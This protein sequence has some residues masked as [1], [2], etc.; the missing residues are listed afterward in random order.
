MHDYER[1]VDVY[2]KLVRLYPNHHEYYLYKTQT[3]ILMGK[4]QDAEDT[5][6][7]APQSQR[8]ERL[9]FLQAKIRFEKGDLVGSKEILR[10]MDETT[11][12]EIARAAV[13]SMEGKYEEALEKYNLVLNAVGFRPD[14]A[15]SMAYCHYRMDKYDEALAILDK[16]HGIDVA[17]THC[18][19]DSFMGMTD[20]SLLVES[21]LI[22]AL[23]LKT[24]IEYD[25]GKLV[26]ACQAWKRMP[27][28]GDEDID[29]ISLHNQ[30]MIHMENDT[31]SGFSKLTYL[32]SNPP[33]PSETLSN[34]LLL[35]CKYGYEGQ[36]ADM[37]AENSQLLQLNIST[38][39]YDFLETFIVAKESTEEA[40]RRFEKLSVI[41]AQNV[42]KLKKKV[43]DLQK[44]GDC[45]ALRTATRS[46][47]DSMLLYVPILMTQTK[48]FW[49]RFDYKNAESILMIAS[50]L[51]ND[52]AEWQLNMAHALF[53]QQGDRYNDAIS[54][55]AT[56]IKKAE[57]NNLLE[58]SPIAIANLCVAYIMVNKNE[59][60]ET[61]IQL[62][63]K[64][65]E[66]CPCNQGSHHSCIVNLVIGTL[67][68]ERGNFEFGIERICKS[69]RPFEE[70]LGA[71]TWYY[72]KL[73]LLALID[74]MSKQMVVVSDHLLQSIQNFLDEIYDHGADISASLSQQEEGCSIFHDR[75]KSI[76]DEA[77]K[78]KC[79]FLQLMME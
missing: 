43:Q 55:Y 15:Y 32:I 31:E 75:K 21:F 38:T 2:S 59:E 71:D 6:E 23:N 36:A 26:E 9:R 5:L 56:L 58:V 39:L 24:A 45:V 3:L 19:N 73:C 65:E 68:C 28:R 63:Q 29:A 78:L 77:R 41:M 42:R 76:S 50:D 49:D 40:L 37:I 72:V 57:K 10:K 18:K 69:L 51:C 60:A 35:Y 1:A 20:K 62:L 30:A 27:L 14:V 47:K 79:I 44:R 7:R 53:M 67:Y 48:I 34:L 66:N 25:K 52:T 8:Q 54:Y 70:K 16:F 33:Y 64:Q 13:L 74:K 4:W 17:V 22:E 12:V 46:M 61:I 11:D